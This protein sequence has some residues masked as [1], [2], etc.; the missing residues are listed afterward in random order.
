MNSPTEEVLIKIW[1]EIFSIDPSQISA[2][3]DFFE[4]GGDP[5]KAT[6]LV[7]MIEQQC[8]GC[9]IPMA[10]IFEGSSLG[11]LAATVVEFENQPKRPAVEHQPVVTS[12]N[13]KVDNTPI[14]ALHGDGGGGLFF[15]KIEPVLKKRHPFHM[16]ESGLLYSKVPLSAHEK[17]V[18]EIAKCYL[19]TIEK[20]LVK[21]QHTSVIFSG[22]SFGGLLAFE[23][24]KSLSA[25]GYRIEQLI[26]IDTPNP[27]AVKL[28]N[29]REKFRRYLQHLSQP[30]RFIQLSRQAIAN[31]CNDFY[32][33]FNFKKQASPKLRS[34]DL[35]RFYTRIAKAYSP[36][37]YSGDM[38]VLA[39]ESEV[40]S[41][42]YPKDYGWGELVDQLNCVEVPGDHFS[43]VTPK[44]LPNLAEAFSE[45]V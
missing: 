29:R 3:D 7:S 34:L 20:T 13:T 21:S 35:K 44:H 9:R 12:I 43:M 33:K 2:N 22:Y 32:L 4:M 16:V 27:S 5:T 23:L 19:P 26:I 37:Y 14:F 24:A 10:K 28:F 11:Q 1:A 6:R 31:R 17:P 41:Y 45:L 36:T 30:K 40:L 39:A 38:L 8:N 18:E 42:Q 15:A 25:Q